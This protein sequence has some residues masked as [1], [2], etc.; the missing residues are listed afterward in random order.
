MYDERRA[1]LARDP[2]ACAEGFRTLVMLT[3]RHLFG[4]RYCPDCPNCAQS[5]R[6]CMD[7]FGSNATAKGGIFGRID[8][9]YGSH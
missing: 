3:L 9:I 8:A 5:D 2:L 1:L 7:A 6:P 4:V